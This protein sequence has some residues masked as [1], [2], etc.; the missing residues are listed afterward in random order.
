MIQV[1]DILLYNG[2]APYKKKTLF[3][4]DIRDPYITLTR[5]IRIINPMIVEVS[6]Y[7]FFERFQILLRSQDP[8]L[9]PHQN[10]FVGLQRDLNHLKRTHTKIF[11][12]GVNYD[13]SR[14]HISI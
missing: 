13:S 8:R 1:G 5:V 12:R 2:R 14:G 3:L 4:Q 7:F 6:G 9:V 10:N 11:L